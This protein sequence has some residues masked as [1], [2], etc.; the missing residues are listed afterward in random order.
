VNETPKVFG[1]RVTLLQTR[2]ESAHTRAV[3]RD[4][5]TPSRGAGRDPRFDARARNSPQ[6]PA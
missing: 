1:R 2:H 3:L 4:R 5:L 6:G